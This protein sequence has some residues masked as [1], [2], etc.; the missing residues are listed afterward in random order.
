MLSSR[1][2]KINNLSNF[3][4]GVLFFHLLECLTE[5]RLLTR[6]A[7]IVNPHG[8]SDRLKNIERFLS[9]LK[10]DGVAVDDLSTEG[11]F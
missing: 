6:D 5:R 9:I 2:L 8:A 4:E 10:Q 1:F 3:I 11:M 7:V